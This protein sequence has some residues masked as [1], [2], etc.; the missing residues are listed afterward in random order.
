MAGEISKKE[1]P[2]DGCLACKKCIAYKD[3]KNVRADFLIA[4]VC[5]LPTVETSRCIVPDSLVPKLHIWSE[6]M[7]SILVVK[8]AY[9][10]IRKS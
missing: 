3:L 2:M 10:H 1:I 6:N 4:K 5:S 9:V 7:E 8:Q